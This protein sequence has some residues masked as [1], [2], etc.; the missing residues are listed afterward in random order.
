M[1]TQISQNSNNIVPVKQVVQNLQ[2][3]RPN[4]QLAITKRD[5]ETLRRDQALTSLSP[6]RPAS[7]SMVPSVPAEPADS[8]IEEQPKI[9]MK[10]VRTQRPK[11][12]HIVESLN[13]LPKSISV[14]EFLDDNFVINRVRMPHSGF[15]SNQKDERN[16]HKSPYRM[17]QKR[18]KVN[19]V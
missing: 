8:L 12:G 4:R 13:D 5:S 3:K 18:P 14:A 9:D 10:Q 11:T 19:Q 6:L 17:P 15:S 2:A 1:T 16:L 7:L